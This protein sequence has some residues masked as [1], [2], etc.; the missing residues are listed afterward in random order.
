MIRVSHLTKSQNLTKMIIIDP[1][2]TLNIAMVLTISETR[3]GIGIYTYIA[4][5]IYFY[6]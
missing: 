1:V 6:V 3:L 5:A 2:A 4:I